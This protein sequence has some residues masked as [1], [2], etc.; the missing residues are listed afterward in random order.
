MQKIPFMDLKRQYAAHR[1]GLLEAINKV[2]EDAAFS[3]GFYAE[4]FEKEFAAYQNVKYMSGVSCG[5]SALHLSMLALGIGPGDEVIVPANTFIASAWG[6]A[7]AGAAPV[8]VDCTPDTWEIDHSKIEAKINKKTK[9]IIGVHLYGQTFDITSVKAIADKYRLYLVEDCA[10]A[11]GAEYKNN[12]VGGLG[13]IG[14]FS[15]YPGK[16]LGAYGEGGA[17][18]S[19]NSEYIIHINSLKNHGSKKKYYHDEVGYNYRLEGIQGAVLSYKLKFLDEWTERRR[20]IAQMYIEGITNKNIVMQK[21][22]DFAKSVF[23]LFVI[24][25]PERE[26]FIAHLE[27]NGIGYGLHYPCPCHLQK[28]FSHLGYKQ[29]QFPEAEYLAKHCLSLP[30]FPELT[31]KEVMQVIDVC[32]KFKL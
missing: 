12:R 18:C 16:N 13:D 1:S 15:F 24:T 7:H 5:T 26:R 6:P 8:F 11:H 4:K 25:V 2:C 14:C 9:A 29:G 3:G 10:Q 23:H 17:V 20:R 21:Q 32:N 28:A 19:N 31:D 30:M 22:P 27:S